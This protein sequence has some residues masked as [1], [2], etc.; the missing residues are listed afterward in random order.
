[1]HSGKKYLQIILEIIRTS[2]RDC[3]GDSIALYLLTLS[4]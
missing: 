4:R 2:S 1:V 3:I